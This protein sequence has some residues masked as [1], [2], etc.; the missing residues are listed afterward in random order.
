[1]LVESGKTV[2]IGG[3]IKR[4]EI[5]TREGVPVL[6]DIPFLGLLF[7]NRAISTVNTELVVLITP[8]IM[9][10]GRMPLDT[11]KSAYV[12]K[13]EQDLETQ[14]R[15]IDEIMEGT[16]RFEDSLKDLTGSNDAA[17]QD[18]NLSWFDE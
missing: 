15:K 13:V 4:S 14:P 16:K 17:E 18:D 1:M 10:N 7:S 8:Y 6:G 5:K 11:G 3:L 9:D 12:E 2:F